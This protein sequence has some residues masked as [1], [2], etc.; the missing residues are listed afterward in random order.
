MTVR[1]IPRFVL[2]LT[3]FAVGCGGEPAATGP[4][5]TLK[6]KLTI[7]GQTPPANTGIV[8]QHAAT[9]RLFLTLTNPAGEFVVAKPTSTM[10]TGVYDVSVQ[11]GDTE[12]LSPKG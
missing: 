10:P 3:T 12:D 2:L 4:T 11:P 5:G 6:G 9:G 1:M 8:F 7:L